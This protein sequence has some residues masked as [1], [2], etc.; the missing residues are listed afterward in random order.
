MYDGDANSSTGCSYC[1]VG[2]YSSAGSV[3]CTACAATTYQPYTGQSSC[4]ACNAGYQTNAASAAT[5]CDVCSIGTYDND[6][7]S[8]TA[9]KIPDPGYCSSTNGSSCSWANVGMIYQYAC[10]AG[11]FDSRTDPTVPNSGCGG[12]TYSGWTNIDCQSNSRW[13]AT[14]TVASV[15]ISTSTC[16][17]T[18]TWDNGACAYCTTHSVCGGY[19]K[20]DKN[21]KCLEDCSYPSC[22]WGRYDTSYWDSWCDEDCTSYCYYMC[23]TGQ[24][25]CT[26]IAG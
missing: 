17:A 19:T 10:P 22:P 16:T 4:Y 3:S 9:C 18:A 15:G 11:Y 21:R 24:H 1:A 26:D 25:V 5:T 2:H 23:N 8:S 6:S 12:C 14:R 7:N 20:V 13:Y